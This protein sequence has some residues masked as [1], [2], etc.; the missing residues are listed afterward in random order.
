MKYMA[1]AIA[2]LFLMT[3]C[4]SGFVVAPL[5]E[6]TPQDKQCIQERIKVQGEKDVLE[7]QC[8]ALQSDYSKIKAQIGVLQ[9]QV[10][11]CGPIQTNLEAAEAKISKLSFDLTNCTNTLVVPLVS[12]NQTCVNETIIVN[13]TITIVNET[14]LNEC[15]AELEIKTQELETCNANLTALRSSLNS[16]ST[17]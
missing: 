4:G 15:R 12:C 8:Q 6:V 1:I 10:T 5:D 13:N 7:V 3:G 17:G 9:G 16:N 14:L 11:D 2:C